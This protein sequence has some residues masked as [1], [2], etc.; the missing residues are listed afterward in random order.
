V[1]AGPAG[2]HWSGLD[3]R[4]LR[5]HLSGPGHFALGLL[6]DGQRENGVRLFSRYAFTHV[7]DTRVEWSYD[8][9]S[10]R[11][12]TH[13]DYGLKAHDGAEPE[14]L[15]ALYPHQRA[16]QVDSADG[17]EL[18]TYETVR[19]RMSL[20]AGRGF[21]L[22][23]AFP[24]VLPAL[25]VLPGTDVEALRA[26]VKAEAAQESGARD[27]YWA[28]KFLGRMAAL[29]G[30][31]TEIGLDTEAAAL[32]DR[33]R[34]TLE[35]WFRPDFDPADPGTGGAFFYEPSWGTLIGYP[36][37]YGSETSLNDHHFHYGYFLRA[38]AELGRRDRAW[39][40]D[41]GYGPF[42]DLLVRD[43]A[44]PRR[45]DPKFPFL[46]QFDPY[47]GHSWASG[48]GVA[49]DGN[50]QESS[51]EAIAAW[52]G[53]ILLGELRGDPALRDL[54]I[55]LYTSE[56]QAIEAYWFDVTGENFPPDYPNEAVPMIWGGKGAYGT[57]FS[58]EPE[59]LY[60]I[61]WLPFHGGSLY[62]GRWPGYAARSYQA[63]VRA[64]GGAPWKTWSDLV[65]MYRA[66]SDPEDALRQWNAL[67][68][69]FGPEAGNSRANAFHWISTLRLAG[70][71][72][73]TVRADAPLYAVFRDETR[74]TYVAYNA[75]A[76]PRTV[77]FSD[78][79]RLVVPPN[80]FAVENA[81]V[82]APAP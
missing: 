75:D 30:L 8:P 24:G 48:D 52:T 28:G 40:S 19:G 68:P 61:N 58:G 34:A 59:H 51:S 33:L 36:G 49:G 66:L 78:G 76:A 41:A 16:A 27:T 54:G 60:G 67:G 50:N 37:S 45:D 18:G 69:G 46:R 25:P 77:R 74:R 39:I 22:E 4:I 56:L 80:A 47:A 57:Y 71:V 53:L 26:L 31:A 43:I 29:H 55:Y 70:R 63:L 38:A 64:R 5:N 21:T 42:L 17:S 12:R 62:L 6:P 15:F 14:T 20:R 9:S 10:A 79:A 13:F 44:D 73:R 3:Q 11:V 23:E 65:V 2:S 1:L 7:V 81:A 72:D 35:A 82:A 32:E